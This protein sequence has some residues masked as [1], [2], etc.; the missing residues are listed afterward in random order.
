MELK[1]QQ[2]NRNSLEHSKIVE[3]KEL[4]NQSI[5]K[6]RLSRRETIRDAGQD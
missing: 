2:R 6:T 4:T 3:M 1:F 5:E